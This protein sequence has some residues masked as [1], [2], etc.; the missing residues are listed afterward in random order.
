MKKIFTVIFCA[1]FFVVLAGAQSRS[2]AVREQYEKEIKNIPA[3]Q[4]GETKKEYTI[5][6]KREKERIYHKCYHSSYGR[7]YSSDCEFCVS[8]MN[9]RQEQYLAEQKEKERKKAVADSI[10]RRNLIVR[11]SLKTIW[12]S[13]KTIEK[14]KADSLLRVFFDDSYKAKKVGDVKKYHAKLDGF[15]HSYEQIKTLRTAKIDALEKQYPGRLDGEIFK[16]KKSEINMLMYGEMSTLYEN[17]RK[18]MREI[19]LIRYDIIKDLTEFLIDNGVSLRLL[20]VGYFSRIHFNFI[21]NEC[22]EYE[23]LLA[24]I[25]L[26][27]NDYYAEHEKDAKYWHLNN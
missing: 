9:E 18:E 22:A 15:K 7:Y 13:L 4:K 19:L 12:E 3:W 14:T 17:V 1:L 11:D 20:P 26:R 6:Y 2:R 8:E 24:S 25:K 27:C 5:R 10:E 23:E 21:E 16:G